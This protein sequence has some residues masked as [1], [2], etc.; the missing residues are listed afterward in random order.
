MRFRSK[1][2][3][4]NK[5]I[6]IRKCI[7]SIFVFV[8]I[9]G[10]QN[11]SYSD[12][13]VVSERTPQV[14]DAIV[15]AIPDA[16]S[17][18]EITTTHLTTITSLNLRN[19]GITE[20]QSGDF[21]GLTGLI[22]LNLYSNQLS[23]L[24]EGIFDGLTALTSL[25]LGG[26]TVDPLT[27]GVSLEKVAE[28][29][30]R[31]VTREGAPFNIVL[32][33]SV[34]NGALE[35]N[36][37]TITIPT[38]ST[39]SRTI[40]VTATPSDTRENTTADIG[41]LPRLP[42]T[43][44]GYTLNKSGTLPIVASIGNVAPMFTDGVSVTL[45]VD[46]NTETDENIGTPITAIDM[47]TGDTLTYSLGGIDAALFGIDR[48]TGQL[49]TKADLDYETKI[50]YS[51][52]VAVS[53]G[54]L[55]DTITVTINVTDV[56]DNFAPT[57]TD[58]TITVRTIAENTAAD[59]NI[60]VSITAIDTDAEA[61]I[62]DNTNDPLTYTLGGIDAAAFIIDTETGQLKTKVA[63]DYEQK[64]LY[65]VSVT[66]SDGQLT[67]TIVVVIRLIDIAETDFVVLS[68][69]LSER[70]SQVQD[71]I[72]DN[73]LGEGDIIARPDIE[74]ITD[75]QI[76]AISVLDLR[77]AG[78]TEL[79]SG[80]FS[81]M[82]E[83]KNINLHDNLLMDLPVGIFEGLT[84]L[85]TLRLGHNLLDP[86]PILV[87][88]QQVDENEFQ[89]I[90]P[91]GAPFDIVVPI[92]VTNGHISEGA[93]TATVLKGTLKSETFTIVPTAEAPSVDIGKL[94]G[95]PRNHYGYVL[96]RSTACNRTPELVS[97]IEA[98][99][100]LLMHCQN[101]ANVDLAIITNLNLV[102][103]DIQSLRTHDFSGMLSLT[104]LYLDNNELTS[105]PDKLFDRLFS[106]RTISLRGNKLMDLP[107]GIFEGIVSL[108]S[109]ELS[110]NS[111]DPLPLHVTLEQVGEGAFKAVAH[112]GAPFDI[113]LTFTTTSGSIVDG[114]DSIT[115]P[116]GSL[117]SE[118]LTVTRTSGTI[119]AV[120]VDIDALPDLPPLHAGYAL[121]RSDALPI[122]VIP[123]INVVPVFPEGTSTTRAIAENTES[124]VN[125]GAAITAA[126]A[127]MDG[128][129]YSLDGTD[130]A[131]FDIDSETGQ[132]KTKAAL[133][134]ETKSIYS[135]IVTV[136]D[137]VL[138]ASVDVVIN[139]TDVVENR[140]P[141]FTEGISATRSV[142]ENTAAE[143][144]IGDAVAATDPNDDTLTY[145]LDDTDDSTFAIDTATGQLKTKN[146]L[147]F[148]TKTSYSVKV[149]V[150]DG[151]LTASID[152]VINI[153]DV[154]ENRSPVFT[155][156]T[157]TTR[158]IPEN[159]HTDVNIGSVVAA[160][161]PDDDKLT[162]SLG[163]ID[164]AAFAI[165]PA[166]GQLKTKVAL[167]FETKPSY[168]VKVTVSDGKLT[169]SIDV[170][171]NITDVDENRSPVFTEDTSTTR[172]IPENTHADVNIGRA[173]AATDPDDDKLTYS[174]G[175]IDAAAFA[176]N[177]ATGQ[178]KTKV[179]LDFETKPSYSVKVTVSDGK[180][181]A[182]IDVVINITDRDEV[183]KDIDAPNNAP[184]FTEGTS[185]TR[186][187]AENTTS[188][189]NIGDPV[190]A[191]DE[192]NDVLT[193]SLDG[194]DAG[195][196]SID[197]GSGQ[198][199]TNSTLDYEI[200][201]VYTV[202]ITVTDGNDGSAS[203]T[204]TINI[205]D[206]DEIQPNR[207]P[208]FTQGTSTIRYV[209]ENIAAGKN[210]GT[211]VAATDA[212]N[213][214]L[215][216]SLGGVD[217]GSFSFDTSSGQLQTNAALDFETKPSYS[218]TISVSDS[219]GESTSITVTII[220]SDVDETPTD[221]VSNN[222][223]VFTEG[224]ITTRSVAENTA[225]GGIIGTPVAATDADND[226]LTYSLGETPDDNV[227][228]IV[229][230]T[231]QLRTKDALDFE[232]KS[233]YQV[234]ITVSDSKDGSAS[235]TVTIN[236]DDVIEI[237]PNRAPVFTEGTS[238]TRS[239]AENTAAGGIIGTPVAATDADNDTLTYS[240]GET[241]DDNVFDIVSTT[242]QLK[243]FAALDYETKQS[244]TVTITVT[245][246]R[247]GRDTITVTINI[248]DFGLVTTTP[249]AERGPA[250]RDAIVA[251]IPDVT[252]P[253]DVTDE[254][255][256][257]ITYLDLTYD[258]IS[259]LKDGDFEGLTGLTV[260][261]LSDNNLETIP[262]DILDELTSLLQLQLDGN[263]FTSFPSVL[264]Q[265]PSL[266]TLT[267]FGN[268]LGT[269]PDGVFD[270]F[271]SLKRLS[272]SRIGLTSLTVGIFDPLTSL[273][274]LNLS[275]NE[276]TSL[277]E[278]IFDA[279]TTLNYLD[280]SENPFASLPVNI[281]NTLTN[282]VFLD[283]QGA[284][285]TSLLSGIFSTLTSLE[286][287]SLR[288]NKLTA[289][290]DGIFV[291]L[292]SL[293]RLE[294]GEDDENEENDFLFEVAV[295]KVADGQ[296]KFVIAT[297]APFNIQVTFGKRGGTVTGGA[298][299]AT[300]LVGTAE[301]ET[302]TITP[303]TDNTNGSVVVYITGVSDPSGFN[304]GYRLEY[305][306]DEVIIIDA[307]LAP[308]A[309]VTRSQLIPIISTLLP[310]YP[311]PFNPET[312]IPYQL[313]KAADV[314]LT[315]YNVQG[316][317]VR[318]LALGHKHAGYYIGR[319]RATYWDGRNVV[320]EKVAAGVYFYMLKVDDFSATRKL[321]IVK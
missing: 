309:E 71:E 6:D 270:G 289:L 83:L 232:T 59:I 56:A 202:E 119:D 159:T 177:P 318:Q 261:N 77:A 118:I 245:D 240:L 22:Y 62:D 34:T 131:A 134:Y 79:K 78:I 272:I 271:T 21:S 185:T 305:S 9:I 91:A 236:I 317:V 153:T 165:N 292:T 31:A 256:A 229:S 186:T 116:Q 290:P 164:A 313:A 19:A 242:G 214:T 183:P 122:E 94:P 319:D 106:L 210:I 205:D 226:T 235:I 126:D 253:D 163:G 302:L 160:T 208:V 1:R 308:S 27:I 70:T 286:E 199:Q 249:L 102:N 13:I 198:L 321:L 228:D 250:V 47:D 176:I 248:D 200:T 60:G 179:A 281:F 127:N 149:T 207:A 175:G 23:S 16:S 4:M 138:T 18:D 225:A 147:D 278:G 5:L 104:T 107:D 285:L 65:L 101:V 269:L 80:D 303:N 201:S 66:A 230:T 50:F 117:E 29:Q 32:P 88:L 274:R 2:N 255:L 51:V 277:P 220:V 237:Q 307:M 93:T 120:T 296:F 140:P 53:D 155:E 45:N 133:D 64:S 264:S 74:D 315:I 168:S 209:V 173:V 144:N 167:D 157:S 114:I 145:S 30:I 103:M 221:T 100:P 204:V 105:L 142:A 44:F 301:S 128:L 291:G 158:T 92:D 262:E 3:R 113:S 257:K 187:I 294:L 231:G 178:L 216:Y 304:Y 195:S 96:A 219:S 211:P 46:E 48:D 141:V 213:D 124:G 284:S 148:E 233:S 98:M 82:T 152:V 109:L 75:A 26:N 10:I 314:S 312:W 112:T 273:E 123:R 35:D 244:Y 162:Y 125:V 84:A 42:R 68:L 239:V 24:P 189:E 139:V 76:A 97:A 110:G 135:V 41:T 95:L 73:V 137:G 28:G 166:T 156:D 90:V 197:S 172:T 218:V 86:M 280:I 182:S 154:D 11:T 299:S 227:F 129:V 234:T 203:I 171:I 310:N 320:G 180:L 297:G 36:A 246:G 287:L 151:S 150:S 161:D 212:D 170:V 38:G 238:P 223:P 33:I 20:L 282:L 69:P 188:D 169:A 99:Y 111:V 89:V 190:T 241:P 268:N 174:L 121:V 49:K 136:S 293:D 72:V 58:G 25:R 279:L 52:T 55:T 311:N 288:G 192:D 266:E 196:F 243:T 57:F 275:K 37:T 191:I 184:V 193:Y 258:R 12:I 222:A 143:T 54:L 254:Q 215:T 40:T 7:L 260:L 87:S 39:A 108:E 263:K 267:I 316:V 252:N 8:I 67:D 265:L 146:P 298:N 283:I 132:L 194:T 217:A 63:L 206:V 81:G 130:A 115:I 43:H 15:A 17:A 276:L 251:A 295:E 300:I 247:G 61:D 259:S 85:T 306:E 224:S 14:R 181:T